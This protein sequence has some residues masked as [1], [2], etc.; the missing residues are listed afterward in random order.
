MN[1]GLWIY[2][3]HIFELRLK[4]WIW[5]S[6]WVQILYRPKFFLRPSF[7]YC[8]LISSV[9][10]CEDRFHIHVF[11]RSSNIW[12]SHIHNW[13]LAFIDKNGWLIIQGERFA[14]PLSTWQ[15]CMKGEGCVGNWLMILNKCKKNHCS[16]TCVLTAFLGAAIPWNATVDK[17]DYKSG[18]VIGCFHHLQGHNLLANR[19]VMGN[20]T[21][22]E[23]WK[24]SLDSQREIAEE[25]L[26]C[27]PSGPLVN[28]TPL[29]HRMYKTFCLLPCML[30]TQSQSTWHGISHPR[31]Y[32]HPAIKIIY[33]WINITAQ[34]ACVS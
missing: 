1:K 27:F 6:S 17:S 8:L 10:Y 34:R 7:H 4:T 3:S 29:C 14:I 5:S 24:G 12:L 13:P 11:N 22:G 16:F 9:H 33:K 23:W 15:S 21:E 30:L 28:S 26:T 19:S 32:F 20:D 31:W 2:E 25:I 18:Y